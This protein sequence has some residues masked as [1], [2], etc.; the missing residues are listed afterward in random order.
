M[1][2][3]MAYN[4]DASLW[5]LAGGFSYNLAD[6]CKLRMKVDKNLQLGTNMQFQLKQGLLFTIA[7]NLDLGNPKSGQHSV[8]LSLNMC[9]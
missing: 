5:Y 3:K 4:E 1:D 7:F 9:A 2:T 8:G 6:D